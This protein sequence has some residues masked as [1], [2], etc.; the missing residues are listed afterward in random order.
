MDK[1]FFCLTMDCERIAAESPPGGPADWDASE[2]SILGFADILRGEGMHATFFIVPETAEKHAEHWLRLE[3]EAFELGLH[4]HPQSLG[5]GSWQ[6][7]L[8]AYPV[9]DQRRLLDIGIE[10]WQM[11]LG[12][13]PLAFRPGNFSASD[14]T[15]ALLTELGFTH[16]SVSVPGRCAPNF[17][18]VWS[19]AHPYVHRAHAAFRLI[20]GSLPFV[21]IPVTEDLTRVKVESAEMHLPFELRV[22]FGDPDAHGLTIGNA[23]AAMQET[24]PPL[25]VLV[26][27]THNH[28]DYST[29]DSP[30]VQALLGMIGH[31]RRVADEN[32]V[33]LVPASLE[34]IRTEFLGGEDRRESS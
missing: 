24:G 29:A 26:G 2:R 16:G 13:R 20:A 10:I 28:I 30:H 23:L 32:G 15:Y 8:G 4:L 1:L 6:E 7:Y 21:E 19:G 3:G 25:Y 17:R 11:A 33:D 12:R 5:D 18:A 22:E 31:V 9:D 27:M 34:R 14:A